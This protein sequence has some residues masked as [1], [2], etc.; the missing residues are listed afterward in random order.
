MGNEVLRPC[1]W[2]LRDNHQHKCKE[3]VKYRRLCAAKRALVWSI[4]PPC[5]FEKAKSCT[6]HTQCLELQR[7]VQYQLPL[8][9]SY[10]QYIGENKHNDWSCLMYESLLDARKGRGFFQLFS[11]K[12]RTHRI[13]WT[14]EYNSLIGPGRDAKRAWKRATVIDQ[15]LKRGKG[16]LGAKGKKAYDELVNK[17][18]SWPKPVELYTPFFVSGHLA[19]E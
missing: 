9:H 12:E 2:P 4:K 17:P 8:F 14:V 6:K 7:R 11:D 13:P 19:K 1:P 3:C 5:N 16:R 18:M 15:R 10:Y